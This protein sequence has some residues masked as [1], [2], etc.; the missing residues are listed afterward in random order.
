M[1]RTAFTIIELLVVVAIIAILAALL[2]PALRNAKESGLRTACL[3]NVRQIGSSLM[4]YA[5]DYNMWLPAHTADFSS[6]TPVVCDRK[7][8]ETTGFYPNYIPTIKPFFCPSNNRDRYAGAPYCMPTPA[9]GLFGYE[10]LFGNV[11]GTDAYGTH[12]VTRVTDQT[13]GDPIAGRLLQDVCYDYSGMDF[14]TYNHVSNNGRP[15]GVNSFYLDGHAEWL[16]FNR[17]IYKAG[18]GGPMWWWYY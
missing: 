2:L 5:D 8:P 1:K 18:W 16:P 7:W 9:Y 6:A 11:Y 3:N 14:F 10:S 12:Y 4:Q 17:L 15:T 13:T